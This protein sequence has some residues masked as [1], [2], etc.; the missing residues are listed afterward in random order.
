MPL[1]VQDIER[2]IARLSVDDRT[3]LAAYILDSLEPADGN[4]DEI[5]AAWTREIEARIAAYERGEITPIAAD[6]VFAEA[7]R[8][9]P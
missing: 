4:A 6:E 2:E 8:R 9:K 5:E 3:R 7:R 1:S